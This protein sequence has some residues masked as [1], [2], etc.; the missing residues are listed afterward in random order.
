MVAELLLVLHLGESS[1]GVYDATTAQL[2]HTI[3]VSGKPHAAALTADQGMAVV[4]GDSLTLIDL[5]ARKTIGVIDTGADTQPQAIERGASGLFYVTTDSP[6]AVLVL[7]LKK[8]KIVRRFNVP[9]K[10]PH[11]L[12]V[13]RDE[14]KAWT[15]NA[16]S[17]TVTV[18]DLANRRLV[19]EL[20]VGGVPQDLALT[21]DEKRLFVATGTQDEVVLVD[22]VANT[23]RRRIGLKG[24]PA[25]LLLA[26]NDRWLAVGLAQT[27][28][29]A[30]VD[31]R[32]LLET[33]RV[34]LEAPPGGLAPHPD[35]DSL[36]VA[37]P[38]VNT[39]LLMSLPDL[40]KLKVYR[41]G[42]QPEPLSLL[43]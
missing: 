32:T 15:A 42:A 28:E 40:E 25:R 3:P 34:P 10:Q 33:N 9:G 6:P 35:G 24:S 4:A 39:I 8:R 7:D 20:A 27:G 19:T 2:V 26:H 14:F 11:R 17:G 18:F 31:T 37:L 38:G 21:H 1:L 36:F 5:K 22:A 12:V 43:R 16:G 30:L 13:S 41:T 23:V 29:L